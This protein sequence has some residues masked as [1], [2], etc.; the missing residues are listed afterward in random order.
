MSALSARSSLVLLVLVSLL[1]VACGDDEPAAPITLRIVDEAGEAVQT[2]AVF[3]YMPPDASS[4]AAG[5]FDPAQGLLTRVG[6]PEGHDVVVQA[7]GFRTEEVEDWKEDRTLVLRPGF[8]IRI[9]VAGGRNP[10]EAPLRLVFAVQPAPP[11]ES[12]LPDETRKAL[13]E[14]MR[15]ATPLEEGEPDLPSG[16]VGLAVVDTAAARGLRLPVNG[17]YVVRWGVFDP[18]KDLFFS[19]EEGS[20]HAIAVDDDD[21]PQS[22]EIPITQEAIDRAKAELLRRG[23]RLDER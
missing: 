16:D 14:L 4:E 5:S 10:V 18:E 8:L 12:E 20:T 13:V 7:P 11:G 2:A 17:R 23:V 9:Q 22:F 19:L 1:A 21:R 3:V 15:L 6:G